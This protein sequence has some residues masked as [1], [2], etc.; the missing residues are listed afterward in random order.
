MRKRVCF[1]V[2]VLLSGA[3][4]KKDAGFSLRSI[5]ARARSRGRGGAAGGGARNASNMR[6]RVKVKIVSRLIFELIF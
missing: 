1:H 5:G 6:H 2:F 3:H 4:S